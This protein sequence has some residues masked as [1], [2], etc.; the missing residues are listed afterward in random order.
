MLK[1]IAILIIIIILTFPSWKELVKSGWFPMHDDAQIQR[2]FLMH[3]SLQQG[4]FPVRSVDL[5]GYGYGYPLFN[6]YNPLPYYFGALIMFI[7]LNA[8]IA[9]K[10]IFIIP[11]ILGTIGF[12]LFARQ[13]LK[14][15]PSLL[16]AI[17]F[18]YAP[19]HG[20][21]VYVR[22]A[23]AESWAY[24]LIPW[25]FYSLSSRRYLLASFLL[26]LLALSHNLTVIT[27]I[28]FLILFFIFQKKKSKTFFS[29]FKTILL[30]LALSAFF[31]L[32]AI[33]EVGQTRVKEMIFQVEYPPALHLI[34]PLQL[35]NSPIGYAGSAPGFSDGMSF[36]LGKIHILGSILAIFLL[37]LRKKI[38]P[39]LFYLLTLFIALFLLLPFSKFVWANFS[40][41]NF[42]Q[43]PWRFFSFAILAAS[44]LTALFF[45]KTFLKP[46]IPLVI[47]AAIIL[48]YK[49]FIPQYL[50]STTIAEQTDSQKIIW[51]TSKVSDEYLP[52]GFVVPQEGEFL[53]ETDHQKNIQ[54]INQVKQDTS[55]R[56]LGNAISLLTLTLLVLAIIK[57]YA[58]HRN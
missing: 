17:L 27:I 53:S 9:T 34:N 6:F 4:Q 12:F 31:W 55:L 29:W 45:Q 20:T 37:F 42:I 2:V 26:A 5:L 40:F 1:K 28:P 22:G 43:F 11:F 21:L 23:L 36:Q 16:A 41:L 25:F 33:S 18:N 52:Q 46:F 58:Y 50:Y 24:A 7:G 47:L 51:Y 15:L 56:R 39:N 48:N 32:P 35:W 10:I 54:L 44:F 19:Y 38:K 3:Q 57:P 49:F 14:L 30:A 13:K 8:L